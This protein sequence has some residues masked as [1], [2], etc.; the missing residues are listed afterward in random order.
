M[1]A[2]ATE[3]VVEKAWKSTCCKLPVFPRTCHFPQFTVFE[4]I[5]C[6][7]ATPSLAPLATRTSKHVRAVIFRTVHYSLIS[8]AKIWQMSVTLRPDRKKQRRMQGTTLAAHE[9]RHGFCNGSLKNT[10]LVTVQAANTERTR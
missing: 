8:L 5:T 3:D 9:E 4:R 6:T 10:R 7:Q 2:P 1:R